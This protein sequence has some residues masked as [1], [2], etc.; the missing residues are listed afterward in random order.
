MLLIKASEK[1]LNQFLIYLNG[2]RRN[3]PN[4]IK[5]YRTDVL[6]FI[7][8]CREREIKEAS[9]VA[10]KK[11]L[12]KLNEDK[13]D[14]RSISRKL[15]SLRH[16]FKFLRA[17]SIIELNPISSIHNPKEIKKLPEHLSVKELQ[18]IFD[19]LEKQNDRQS[20]MT[21]AIFDLLYGCALRV[22]EVCSLRISD[23]D[24]NQ[25]VARVL[26]KGSKQ[27]IVPIGEKT[28]SSLKKYLKS[29]GY[30]EN[31]FFRTKRG[32]KIYPEFVERLVKKHIAQFSDVKKKSPHTLRHSAATHMLDRGADLLAI[33]EILGHENLSTT[34][35]YTHVSVEKLKRTYKTSHPKS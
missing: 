19:N 34:Q 9:P 7:E 23:L 6:Q 27:R 11:F 35:I 16:F 10:I 2:V 17:N 22:S 14:K 21:L 25:K 1:Y 13:L 30:D 26:G 12:M 24:F 18:E 29:I 3:S 4:T 20:L 33:K 8:F 15:S 31:L 5:A 32:N 28:I